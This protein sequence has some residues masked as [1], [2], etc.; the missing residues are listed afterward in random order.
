MRIPLLVSAIIGLLSAAASAAAQGPPS[1]APLPSGPP[2]AATPLASPAPTDGATG[3]TSG[4]FDLGGRGTTFSGD[5]ARYNQFRDLSNGLFLDN[6][7]TSAGKAGWVF[8]VRGN[9]AGRRDAFY[10]GQAVR[11]GS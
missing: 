5:S 2:Q 3:A 6:F 4:S 9:N 8:D 11:P 7:R 1:S 10:S